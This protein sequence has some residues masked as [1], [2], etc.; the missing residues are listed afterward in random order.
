MIDLPFDE[1][2]VVALVCEQI[3]DSSKGPF[4]S[5]VHVVLAGVEHKFLAGLVDGIVGEMYEVVLEVFLPRPLI[6]L[7]GKARQSLLVDVDPQRV[8]AVNQHV[9]AHIELQAIDQQRVIDVELHNTDL[10]LQLLEICE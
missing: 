9:D 6:V 10:P 2:H 1:L 4:V 3:E 7:S 5:D 8:A